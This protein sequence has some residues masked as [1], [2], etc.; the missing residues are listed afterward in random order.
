MLRGLLER[1]R[2]GGGGVGLP[3]G[4]PGIGKTRTA[5]VL[6][7][8]ARAHG[9][10]VLW[11]R[12]HEGDGAP[13]FWPWVQVLRDCVA[14]LGDAELELCGPV[15]AELVPEVRARLPR[16]PAAPELE[17]AQARFRLFDW[18]GGSGRFEHATRT[19][20]WRPTVNPDGT[21]RIV[22]DGV[23]DY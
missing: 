6:A 1:A 3:V 2:A 16:F 11:R 13:A 9:W 15:L 20:I 12:C 10:G 18:T 21:F 8:E 5:G 22:A 19:T 7:G 23:I 17:P 14:G 4:E